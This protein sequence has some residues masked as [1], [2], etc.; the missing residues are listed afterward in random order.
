MGRALE[1]A[2]YSTSAP[3]Y[4]EEVRP[5]CS[6]AAATSACGRADATLEEIIHVI[7]DYGYKLAFPSGSS[8]EFQISNQTKVW[9]DFTITMDWDTGSKV[10]RDGRDG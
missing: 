5:S 2:G 4:T 6:G 8:I 9:E 3:L 1:S 7:T 10:I